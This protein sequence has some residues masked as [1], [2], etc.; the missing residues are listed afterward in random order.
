MLG[1]RI[2]RAVIAASMDRIDGHGRHTARSHALAAPSTSN[3]TAHR[4]PYPQWPS[5]DIEARVRKAR[6]GAPSEQSPHV[7][8]VNSFSMCGDPTPSNS[9]SFVVIRGTR[10]CGGS[11]PSD[12]TVTLTL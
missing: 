5:N 6:A 9:A 8:F 7:D 2:Q 1:Q 3:D 11:C 10:C 12:H 4:T